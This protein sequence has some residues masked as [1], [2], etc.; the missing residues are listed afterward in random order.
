VT[1]SSGTS[2]RAI[3]FDI[4]RVIVRVDYDRALRVLSSGTGRSGKEVWQLISSD[5]RM[6]DFQE[7]RLTPQEWHQHL[8]QLLNMSLSYEEFYNSWTSALDPQPI[9]PDEVFAELAG[10]YHMALLSNTD[11]IHVAYMEK[12]FPFMSFF[13]S[14][15]YSCSVGKSKPDPAIYRLA[16]D[17]VQTAPAET[18]YVD[19][20]A[21][22]IEAG[23]RLG[24]QTILF[25]DLESLLLDLR[26]LGLLR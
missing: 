10:R 1:P 8:N 26:A 2:L 16:L 6:L 14:R 20:V 25:R 13:P 12:T 15:I 24:M 11:P 7:G 3:I 17:A 18:L 5:P 4:G 21:E 19:D 9:I 23:R 22:Y